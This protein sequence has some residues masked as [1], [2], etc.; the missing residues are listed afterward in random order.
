MRILI[1]ILTCLLIA[2]QAY[3]KSESYSNDAASVVFYG[4]TVGGVL[5]PLQVDGTGTVKTSGGGGG[6]S[7]WTTDSATKT[8]TTYNVGIGSV[9]PTQALDVNGTIRANA[10][11]GTASTQL[12]IGTNQG[13]GLDGVNVSAS[14]PKL[15]VSTNGNV[16]INNTSPSQQL[17]VTGIVKATSYQGDGS[18]LTGIGASQWTTVGAGINYSGGNVGIGSAVP[19]QKLDVVGTL[20]GTG[21]SIT[22]AGTSFTIT[23]ANVGIGSATPGQVLDVTGTV[24]GN[25]FTSNNASSHAGQAACWTTSG[26]SGYCTAAA[27]IVASGTCSCTAL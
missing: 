20:K 6:A 1:A 23:S 10:L 3:A 27:S 24:R 4:K 14:A 13:I 19:T 16:G 5:V 15:T 22:S 7:G 18:A 26:Q 17:E 11:A 25:T 12:L 2:S 21:L 9:N 8:T